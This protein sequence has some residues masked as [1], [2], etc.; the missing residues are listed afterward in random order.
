MKKFLSLL[1]FGAVLLFG[2]V[3]AGAQQWLATQPLP[4]GGE[5]G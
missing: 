4:L 1:A 5:V 2:T 3:S